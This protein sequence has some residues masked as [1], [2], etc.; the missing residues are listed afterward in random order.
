MK[1]TGTGVPC[2][3]VLCFVRSGDQFDLKIMK[4]FG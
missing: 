4:E 1:F 3:N 2:P